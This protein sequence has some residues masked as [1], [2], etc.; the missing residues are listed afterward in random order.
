VLTSVGLGR[1]GAHHRLHHGGAST[2]A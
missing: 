1:R 2:N